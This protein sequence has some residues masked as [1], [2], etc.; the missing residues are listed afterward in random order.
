MKK[1]KDK[2]VL[3][4]FPFCKRYYLLR[5]WRFIRE[6]WIN[7]TNAWYRA[8]RGIAPVD[9]WSFDT[10][11]NNIIPYGLRYLA[12]NSHGW[13]ESEEFPTF[14]D[15]A[16]HLRALADKWEE[17]FKDWIEYDEENEYVQ[18]LHTLIKQ[19]KH[20]DKKEDGFWFTYIDET[21]EYLELR[22]KYRTR[23]KEI[24]AKY[25]K[26]QHECFVALEKI[27]PTLWD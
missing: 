25:E 10:H 23:D 22:E 19:L 26:M 27:W 5:P 4:D 7:L 12:D 20:N 15:W 3:T 11:L 21:P 16:N 1:N 18:P 17:A 14:D 13:P 8:T 6:C 9:L 2:N 24:H